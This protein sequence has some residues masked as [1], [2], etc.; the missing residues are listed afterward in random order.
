MTTRKDDDLY[1]RALEYHVNPRPGKIEI[2]PT[3]PL[4]NQNDL[5]LAYSP[6]VRRPVRPSSPTP[7][8][9]LCIPRAATWLR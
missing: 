5:A 9:L 2:A 7:M 4:A 1:A 6:G 8:L 3:K